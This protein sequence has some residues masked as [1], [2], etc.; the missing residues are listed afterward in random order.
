MI[1]ICRRGN[2]FESE[3]DPVEPEH[4]IAAMNARTNM[5]PRHRFETR[6]LNPISNDPMHLCVLVQARRAICENELQLRARS[7]ESHVETTRYESAK[8]TGVLI[9]AISAV[10]F[11]S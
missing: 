2:V 6:E 5:A 3:L 9:F 11:K 8:Q 4:P 10:Q 7:Q 1:F